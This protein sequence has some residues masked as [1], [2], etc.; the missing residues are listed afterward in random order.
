MQS[1]PETNNDQ[2]NVY[3]IIDLL[4][5]NEFKEKLTMNELINTINFCTTSEAK[6]KI[7]QNI[8][9]HFESSAKGSHFASLVTPVFLSEIARKDRKLTRY[10]FSHNICLDIFL[11]DKSSFPTYV[12]YICETQ[13]SEIYAI[14]YNSFR[15]PKS[16]ELFNYLR[17]YP[18]SRN[19]MSQL[20]SY[21]DQYFS[22][23]RKPTGKP[24]GSNLYD[25]YADER[26][27]IDGDDGLT[28]FKI[29]SKSKKRSA[30]LLR[31][32]LFIKFPENKYP[33]IS[34]ESLFD[35]IKVHN[36]LCYILFDKIFV[37][38]NSVNVTNQNVTGIIRELIPIVKK[39]AA[40]DNINAKLSFTKLVF[41]GF[42]D[43]TADTDSAIN[44]ICEILENTTP[45]DDI[46][47]KAYQ[48]LKSF[49]DA[50]Q[51]GHYHGH[52]IARDLYKANVWYQF[53]AFKAPTSD[54]KKEANAVFEKPSFIFKL[55]QELLKGFAFENAYSAFSQVRKP[56]EPN[57]S[58]SYGLE[59]FNRKKM[60][61]YTKDVLYFAQV[62][63]HQA[64]LLSD[65]LENPKITPL[66]SLDLAAKCVDEKKYNIA[67][68]LLMR[69][70]EEIKLAEHNVQEN[71]NKLCYELAIKEIETRHP[72]EAFVLF[73]KIPESSSFF[74]QANYFLLFA[75]SRWQ[76]NLDAKQMIISKEECLEIKIKVLE[77]AYL[78]L[79]EALN[80]QDCIPYF[81]GHVCKKI[82]EETKKLFQDIT[83]LIKC[84][85]Q[86]LRKKRGEDVKTNGWIISTPTLNAELKN[87]I[88]NSKN[89]TTSGL[90]K[91]GFIRKPTTTTSLKWNL[92]SSGGW[93]KITK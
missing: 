37:N 92:D 21:Y 24:Y 66:I 87:E 39:E 22:R 67:F 65:A 68:N 74:N 54:V 76:R 34:L 31:I 1:V 81:G 75:D 35:V 80:N 9:D 13:T 89:P 33:N 36:E 12:L 45:K 38:F 58:T 83:M 88:E 19:T 23:K 14:I 2:Q 11:E 90:K 27:L 56:E 5:L 42:D 28:N 25:Y 6:I 71:Y 47:L 29:I 55:G 57:I 70:H 72:I 17:T 73:S 53:I 16:L 41:T 46:H 82:F 79:S 93:H 48:V 32:I 59:E 15:N 91:F 49:A 86:E 69:M 40:T 4:A 7:L 20:L 64:Q 3:E 60:V 85:Q 52:S 77:V 50:L 84:L 30:H 61:K 26:S 8:L 10:I 18:G 62:I 51:L 43:I 78:S 44:M 63:A